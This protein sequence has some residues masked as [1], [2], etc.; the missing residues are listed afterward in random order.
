[1]IDWDA[2]VL[3]P[4]MGVF[5]ED[6]LPTYMP[7]S[8]PSFSLP[9]AVFD[10]EYLLVVTNDDGSENTTRRPVLG[11]RL[12]LFAAPPVQNDKVM[13]PSVGLTYIVREV[14][15]DGHGWAKLML[16]RVAS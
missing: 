10:R 3:G 16:N 5:G 12:S 2:E 4:V 1:M 6:N 11:V 15:P 8:G 13:I 14:Q 9:D 7:V